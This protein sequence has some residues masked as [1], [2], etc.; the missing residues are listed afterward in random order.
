MLQEFVPDHAINRNLSSEN[1]IFD[2]SNSA[3][4]DDLINFCKNKIKNVVLRRA[5]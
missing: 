1:S 5:K 3:I 2:N 4:L